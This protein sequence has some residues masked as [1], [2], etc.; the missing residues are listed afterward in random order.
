MRS[1]LRTASHPRSPAGRASSSR[2]MGLLAVAAAS[3]AALPSVLL[4]SVDERPAES[5][6]WTWQFAPDIV[7]AT[8][9]AAAL[10]ASGLY[11]LRGRAASPSAWRSGSFFAGLALIFLALQSPLDTLGDPHARTG[12]DRDGR[13]AIDWGVYGVPETFVVDRD[14]RIAH[15]HIGPIT[16]KVLEERLRPLIAR[17]RAGGATTGAA[18]PRFTGS[19]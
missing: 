1:T 7:I 15:K 16:P 14:G 9:L 19:P 5:A 13:V 3:L 4:A 11:R 17:L 8:I 2:R 10:Y 18:D 6:W 12:A